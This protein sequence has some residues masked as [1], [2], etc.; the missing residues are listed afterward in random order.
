MSDTPT[1]QPDP[2]ERA[3]LESQVEQLQARLARAEADLKTR[4]EAVDLAA[5]E[6]RKLQDALKANFDQSV[7]LCYQLINAF[8]PLLGGQTRAVADICTKIAKSKYFTERE[9][10]TFIAAAW[11]HDL[12]LIGYDRALLHQMHIAP[13]T[14]STAEQE[15]LRLHPVRAQEL[16]SYI[17]GTRGIGETIRAHHERFGGQGYPDGFA[18][19]TIP[20]TARCLAVV[21]FF[22]ESGL[23]KQQALDAILKQ[24]GTGFDPEAVRLFFKMTQS[25]SLPHQVREIMADELTPGMRLAKGIYSNAGLLLVPEGQALTAATIDKIKNHNMLSSV[26]ER[27]LVFT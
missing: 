27:L 14:L 25:D 18:G 22:V 17:D 20:W 5:A 3:P 24:S 9:K 7:R 26:T 2:P 10:Q 15:A 6:V 12:G 4:A 11:L 16:A 13:G 23:P 19:E 8:D 1:A 21:V